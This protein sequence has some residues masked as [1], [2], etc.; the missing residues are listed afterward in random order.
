M[1]VAHLKTDSAYIHH[2]IS[3]MLSRKMKVCT[4]AM[5][6]MLIRRQLGTLNELA[7]EYELI[8]DVGLIRS[9]ENQAIKLTRVP[10]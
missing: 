1:I 9:H 6:E 7:M 5:S 10:Q 2:W 8:I 3:D 4:K